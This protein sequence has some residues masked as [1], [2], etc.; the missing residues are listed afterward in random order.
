MCK[1]MRHYDNCVQD[2]TADIRADVE[3]EIEATNEEAENEKFDNLSYVSIF[4]LVGLP[5]LAFFLQL[6]PR[7]V[8]K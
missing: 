4:Q 8:G 6:F 2:K 7:V 3:H 1:L 5:H